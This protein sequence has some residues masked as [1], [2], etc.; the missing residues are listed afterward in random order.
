MKKKVATV[1]TAAI[2]LT[3]T[4]WAAE[5][6][7][8]VPAPVP[9]EQASQP[10]KSPWDDLTSLRPSTDTLK[11]WLERSSAIMFEQEPIIDNDSTFAPYRPL[12]EAL[13]FRADWNEAA[14]QITAAKDKLTIVFTVNSD[15]ALANGESRQLPAPVRLQ[16]GVPFVP[17]RFVAEEDK[18]DVTWDGFNRSISIGE[19]LLGPVRIE[20]A[21]STPAWQDAGFADLSGKLEKA[22]GNKL[23]L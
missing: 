1:C 4:A 6:P 17:L 2:L 18:R 16:D 5:T 10:L 14:G 3:Q 13:G 12:L 9:Q 7:E 21:A 15:K 19:S 23:S 22:T 8:L 11:V 20:M